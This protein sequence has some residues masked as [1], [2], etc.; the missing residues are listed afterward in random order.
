M[1]P[2]SSNAQRPRSFRLSRTVLALMLREMSTT[3]GRTPFGYLWAILEPAAGILLLTLV[4]SLALRSAPLGPSF[5]LFY[6][7]GLLPFMAYIDIS[8]KIAQALRFSLPLLAFPAVTYVDAILARLALNTLTQIMVISVVISA[9]VLGLQLDVLI[10][11]PATILAIV[12]ALMLGFGV[13][14][15]NCYLFEAS[16]IWG[17]IWRIATRPLFFISTIFYLFQTV[18]EPYRSYLWFNPLIHIVGQFR[19]GI[20]QTYQGDY[21]SVYYVMGLSLVSALMG[22][23][24]LRKHHRNLMLM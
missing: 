15:L 8:G 17:R 13:G 11:Y 1:P 9:L 21:V 4:F 18:P 16:P 7:T 23:L 20:Y 24:L 5:A 22:L 3:Y 14:V 6:A 12:M 2:V 10:D 19:K